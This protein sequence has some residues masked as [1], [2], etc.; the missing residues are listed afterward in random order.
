MQFLAEVL[1]ELSNLVFHIR[2]ECVPLG[3]HG[4]SEL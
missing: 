1:Y 2:D 3:S 4:H